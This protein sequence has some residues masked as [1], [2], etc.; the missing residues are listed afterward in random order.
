MDPDIW[1]PPLWKEMH[2]K[3]FNY[4]ENPTQQ[5]KVRIVKYFKNIKNRI[6]CDKCKRHYTRELFIDPVENH[7]NSKKK[8]IKWLIDLHNKVNARLGKRIISYK[9]AY[10]LYEN[11]TGD[12]LVI[13]SVFCAILLILFGCKK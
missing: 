8:L 3:T 9:E 5:D 1:G 6:P 10:S 7:V 11:Q 13:S 4:P 12:A 2:I